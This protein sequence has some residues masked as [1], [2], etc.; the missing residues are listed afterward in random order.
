[1]N[2]KPINKNWT[3]ITINAHC[4]KSVSASLRAIGSVKTDNPLIVVVEKFC[5]GQGRCCTG[6]WEQDREGH[7]GQDREGHWGQDR[8]GQ[9]KEGHSTAGHDKT[10]HLVQFTIGYDFE[11]WVWGFSTGSVGLG[12]G[13]V[14]LGTGGWGQTSGQTSTGQGQ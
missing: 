10:G 1:M 2:K 6:H 4:G 14:G 8:D 13:S 12:T 9:T 5:T 7:W 11:V 3:I